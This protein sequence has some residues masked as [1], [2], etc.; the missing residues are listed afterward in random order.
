MTNMATEV[1]IGESG[2]LVIPAQIR[3]ELGLVSG[4][5]LVARIEDD[6]LIFEKAATIK[7][8]LQN[9][10][11]HLKGQGMLDDLIADRRAASQEEA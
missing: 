1:Q 7:K 6:R 4:D 2:R 3:K 10:F 8:R 11:S 9:R 5:R